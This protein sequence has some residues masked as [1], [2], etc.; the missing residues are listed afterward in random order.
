MP[1]LSEVIKLRPQNVMHWQH[2]T[3]KTVQVADGGW[4][5]NARDSNQRIAANIVSKTE[6]IDVNASNI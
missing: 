6:M 2:N 5:R 4:R 3:R 1:G